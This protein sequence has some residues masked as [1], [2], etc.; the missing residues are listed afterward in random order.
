MKKMIAILFMV[1][2]IIAIFTACDTNGKKSIDEK[3]KNLQK[4][5][6]Q[7]M[8][9]LQKN[10]IKQQTD[11]L[12][13]NIGAKATE[14]SLIGYLFGHKE[15]GIEFNKNTTSCSFCNLTPYGYK[16]PISIGYEYPVAEYTVQGNSIILD[17]TKF[18]T[19]MAH[20]TVEDY[21][22][23]LR[24]LFAKENEPEHAIE[25]EIKNTVE[26]LRKEHIIEKLNKLYTE[27]L[28]QP[29]LEGELSADKK[30]ITFKKFVIPD[31]DKIVTYENVTFTRQ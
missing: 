6:E 26:Y 29:P 19:V 31:H 11:I 28:K 9:E 3:Q 21:E 24:E 13:G 23:F 25:E 10:T 2:A 22:L 1:L 17:F 20:R 15:H 4:E 5:K 14:T 8:K 30:S 7:K 27:Y 16:Q 12:L 18:S